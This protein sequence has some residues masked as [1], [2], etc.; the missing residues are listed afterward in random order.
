[1]DS[2]DDNLD[3]DL[4]KAI[5]QDYFQP[6][7]L[8]TLSAK[9]VSSHLVEMEMPQILEVLH[10]MGPSV[11]ILLTEFLVQFALKHF[12]STQ[13]FQLARNFLLM[14]DSENALVLGSAQMRQ[15][16]PFHAR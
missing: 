7:S 2:L 10:S 1:L 16:L 3:E 13:L 9:A 15:S 6:K 12:N 5:A 11:H 8:I 4:F 14:K